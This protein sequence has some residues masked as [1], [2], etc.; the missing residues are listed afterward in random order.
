MTRALALPLEQAATELDE[1]ASAL[2]RIGDDRH[3]VWLYSNAAY[4][5]LMEGDPGRA[6]PFLAQALPLA[7]ELGYPL[8]LALACGNAGLEAL[9][10]GD[11]DRAQAAFAEQLR[12]CLEQVSWLAADGLAGFAAVAARRADPELAARLLGAAGAIGPLSDDD[13]TVRLRSEFLEPARRQLGEARWREA[14]SE[15]ARLAFGEAIA[16]ALENVHT[17]AAGD[18][19]PSAADGGNL[20]A[21]PT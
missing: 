8:D 4:N 21:G 7:R 9:F 10:T 13:V 16:L 19:R 20:S 6:R 3:L 17:G 12:I 15:G 1:A 2:R 18:A 14:E 11:L 5:A